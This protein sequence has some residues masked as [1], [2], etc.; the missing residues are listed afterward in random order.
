MNASTRTSATPFYLTRNE[1][2][3]SRDARDRFHLYRLFDFRGRPRLFDLPGAVD[4]FC[5][6]DP[7]TYCA[8]F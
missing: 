1:L 8:H 3:L 6:L 5:T 4:S 7:M 2:A